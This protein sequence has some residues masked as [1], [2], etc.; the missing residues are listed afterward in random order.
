MN[1]VAAILFGWT[2]SLLTNTID[3]WVPPAVGHRH[4][5]ASSPVVATTQQSMALFAS[6]N[7]TDSASEEQAASHQEK[8][9]YVRVEEWDAQ[10]KASLQWDEKV[11]FDGQC[12]GDRW[13]QNEILR[14]NLF[15]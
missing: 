3:A 12:H 9:G 15:K 4:E 8:K 6:H 11:Q 13:Q 14:Q 5:R 7:T 10:Q 2:V 1:A